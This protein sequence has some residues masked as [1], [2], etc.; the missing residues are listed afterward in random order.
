MKEASEEIEEDFYSEKILEE[1]IEDD[2]INAEEE[3]F[4]MGYIG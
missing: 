1:S 2:E 3:G 4:M